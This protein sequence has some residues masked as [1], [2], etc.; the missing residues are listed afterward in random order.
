[1]PS[2]DIRR[3]L[4]PR[5]FHWELIKAMQAAG[6]VRMYEFIATTDRDRY[7]IPTLYAQETTHLF[8]LPKRGFVIR[9]V[10]CE[11]IDENDEYTCWWEGATYFEI[12]T[13]AII[14][15]EVYY[16][17]PHH[18]SDRWFMDD[19]CEP[20]GHVLGTVE[21]LHEPFML[22]SGSRFLDDDRDSFGWQLEHSGALT[23]S[24]LVTFADGLACH[25]GPF[26]KPTLCYKFSAYDFVHEYAWPDIRARF[27]R[28]FPTRLLAD[29]VP[30][31]IRHRESVTSRR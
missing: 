28:G 4:V 3:R 17:C 8:Y 18:E 16:I 25:F 19:G 13:R 31:R 12:D 7:H 6:F 14:E 2:D 23:V 15:Y 30:G 11:R 21:A 24:Q 1:M 26:I 27:W 9:L 29:I 22:R 10:L 5:S 20:L